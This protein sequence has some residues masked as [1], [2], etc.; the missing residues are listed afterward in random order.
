[1]LNLKNKISYETSGAES[2]AKQLSPRPV[3][4]KSKKG[5]ETKL[6]PTQNLNRDAQMNK[7]KHKAGSKSNL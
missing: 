4:N 5:K 1:M 2:S 7:A 3:L 6:P